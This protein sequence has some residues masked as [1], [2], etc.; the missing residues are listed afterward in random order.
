MS[1]STRR[2]FVRQSA[3]LGLGLGLWGALRPGGPVDRISSVYGFAAGVVPDF[4]LALLVIFF[5]FHQFHLIPPPIGRFPVLL[6]A[7]PAI[8]GFLTFDSLLAGDFVA[9][10]AAVG[11][12]VGPVLTLG[13]FFGGPIAK[14][15]RQSM[16]DILQGDVT[17]Y[18]RA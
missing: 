7:P 11:Q 8:T 10:K 9:F 14:L 3:A 17:R 12:L 5:L 4:W 2:D 6:D 16:L 1:R 13:L 18:A 15:T